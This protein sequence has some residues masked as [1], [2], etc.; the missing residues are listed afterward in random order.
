MNRKK[1]KSDFMKTILLSALAIVALVATGF[2]QNAAPINQ[3]GVGVQIGTQTDQGVSFHGAAPVA[4]RAGSA[5]AAVTDTVGSA[6]VTTTATNSSPY[7]YTQA[8]ANA[9]V[10]N[11]NTLRADVITLT[12]LVNELRA[13]LVEKGVIKGSQ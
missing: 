3:T 10:T 9:I 8:Q 1:R 5:Q 7:G 4:Q 12:T 13:A 2:A 11:V 6:V